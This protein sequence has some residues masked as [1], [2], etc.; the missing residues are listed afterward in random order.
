MLELDIR[1]RGIGAGLLVLVGNMVHGAGSAA[2]RRRAR[3]RS[4]G[5][6]RFS[7]ISAVKANPRIS[8]SV[9]RQVWSEGNKGT[10]LY[11]RDFVALPPASFSPGA[12]PPS[13]WLRF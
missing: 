5:V 6:F 4:S 1:M 7:N 10:I 8:C 11:S 13:S 2:L 9:I 3:V 12:A